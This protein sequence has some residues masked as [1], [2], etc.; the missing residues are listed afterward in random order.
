MTKNCFFSDNSVQ[1]IWNKEKKPS[2][3]GHDCKT[4]IFTFAYQTALN[5]ASSKVK[6]ATK[7]E[8]DKIKR[9][10]KDQ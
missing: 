5:Q 3:I 4:L 10:S 6:N 2:K 9:K 8:I 1:N 7:Q